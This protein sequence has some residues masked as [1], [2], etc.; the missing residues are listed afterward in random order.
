VAPFS[1]LPIKPMLRVGITGGIGSGKSTICTIWEQLGAYV[2]YAD[3][4]AKDI[5]TS[6]TS[7]VDAIKLA[8][9]EQAYLEDGSLN[10]PWLAKQAFAENRVDELNRIVHPA[11][12]RESDRLMRE[13]ERSGHPM[14]V[15]EAAILL[16]HGRPTDLDKVVLVLADDD[17]RV[18]RVTAR[19]RFSVD[20]V[21]GRMKAQPDYESYTPLA[22]I[23]IRN[24]GSMRELEEM[25]VAAYRQLV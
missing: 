6:D 3:Q 9:G 16:Q 7:V 12:Y 1:K 13:A 11:V 23:V 5:M 19:D 10:R 8:F 4:L 2:I 14:V 25:A 17:K 22:D 20:Q 24:N 21:S 15:R 18:Q